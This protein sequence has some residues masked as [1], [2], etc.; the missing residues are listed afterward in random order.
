MSLPPEFSRRIPVDGIG[1]DG[2][3]QT[4][5]AEPAECEALA[6]RLGVPAVL[7]LAATFRLHRGEAGRVEATASL[8]GRLVR[9]CVVSL[10]PFETDIGETFS[11]AFVPEAGLGT[12][13]DLD[14]VDEVPYTGGAIDLGEATAEQVAL[15]LDP[16]PRCPG[17]ALPD[18]A[19]E[20]QDSPFAA[21]AQ[22]LRTH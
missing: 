4:V 11:I 20:G 9:D 14:G 7:K 10:E 13:I 17:V 5:T 6:L 22:R 19:T 8:T 1:P 16:Y 21:L 18:A 2:L 12:A 3:V 15:T